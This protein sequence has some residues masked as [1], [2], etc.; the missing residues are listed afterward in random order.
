MKKEEQKEEPRNFLCSTV[1]GDCVHF[2]YE[3]GYA[4]CTYRTSESEENKSFGGFQRIS[5]MKKCPLAPAITRPLHW[6]KD[7]RNQP[8]LFEY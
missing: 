3:R 8:K 2:K 5:D 1:R 6:K 4:V 7:L